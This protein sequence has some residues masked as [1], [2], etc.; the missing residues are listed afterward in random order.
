[1]ENKVGVCPVSRLK[2]TE[3]PK[4]QDVQ[5]NKQYKVNFRKIG[6]HIVDARGDGSKSEFDAEK[7]HKLL[8]HFIDDQGI[9]MPYV[10]MRNYRDVKGMLASKDN[11]I[12]QKDYLIDE[13]N[14]RIGF[15][16]YEA[17][18]TMAYLLK[19]GRR[20]YEKAE[21]V[22][23]ACSSYEAATKKALAILEDK[24]KF[25]YDKKNDKDP[26]IKLLKEDL[27]ALINYSGQ[28]LWEEDLH[29]SAE[30]EIGKYHALYPV[31]ENLM[32]VKETLINV[33]GKAVEKSKEL[34]QEQIQMTKIVEA[35]ETGVVIVH[36]KTSSIIDVNPAA[37][38][39]LKGDKKSLIGLNYASFLKEKIGEQDNK[40]LLM[41]RDKNLVPVL[42]K[43]VEI[44]L[45]HDK[46][47]LENIVDIEE[48]QKYED[49][50]K[51]ALD[52]TEKLN[53]F[54]FNREKRIIEMKKEVN[55]LLNALGKENKYKSVE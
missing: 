51:K 17:P 26:Y 25:R 20:R 15:I 41:N 38:K 6:N 1:M 14:D 40:W 36:P 42:R 2:I 12:K 11:I 5:L 21:V 48:S 34:A 53:V 44:V 43:Q 32:L 10:E 9:E 33:E 3:S 19:S 39:I 37:C 47:A 29:K 52:E 24:S 54:T 13:A 31:V 22:V 23:D 50:L 35:L 46:Y 45:N 18:T 4:W 7:Y 30:M 55:Q 16:A 8:L 49:K 28:F 27:E